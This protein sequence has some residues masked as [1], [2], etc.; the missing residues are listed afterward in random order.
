MF[1]N[2]PS[3]GEREKKQI[4]A[5]NSQADSPDNAT[6]STSRVVQESDSICDMDDSTLID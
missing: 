3:H 5:K 2:D 4:K 6:A 1:Y